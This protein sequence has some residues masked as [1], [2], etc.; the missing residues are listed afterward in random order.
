MT[1]GDTDVQSP[2]E[3]IRVPWQRLWRL[4][5]GAIRELDVL[6]LLEVRLLEGAQY[7][8]GRAVND[9]MLEHAGKPCTWTLPLGTGDAKGRRQR[10]LQL[11]HELGPFRFRDDVQGLSRWLKKGGCSGY[12]RRCYLVVLLK[13]WVFLG[14]NIASV[15]NQ[16]YKDRQRLEVVPRS[17][18][19]DRGLR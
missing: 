8:Q 19:L 18:T 15:L 17:H 9:S 6:K 5:H 4:N 14:H 3:P 13:E 16:A 10:Q 12:W 2:S 7:L 1:S 11:L